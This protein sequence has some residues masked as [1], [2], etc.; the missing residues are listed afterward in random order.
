MRC[1]IC[2]QNLNNDFLRSLDTNR[3][4]EVKKYFKVWVERNV[5]FLETPSMHF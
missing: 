5:S 4:K 2:L 3:F 1:N